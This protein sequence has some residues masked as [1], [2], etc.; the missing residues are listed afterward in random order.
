[1]KK[2]I[3]AFASNRSDIAADIESKAFPIMIALA[4]LYI[5]PKNR[6]RNHWQGEIWA[7]LHTISNLN[8]SNK[9]PS[10]DFILDNTIRCNIK[11]VSSAADAAIDKEEDEIPR[12]HIDI[13]K[14]TDMMRDYFSWLANEL[15]EYR[16]VTKNAVY[17]KLD[18]LGL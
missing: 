16:Y 11:Y 1:M 13:D 15:H 3:K 7:F 9:T 4:Q 8:G 6:N 5:F 12:E 10:T 18:E 14:L 2:Y 17:A